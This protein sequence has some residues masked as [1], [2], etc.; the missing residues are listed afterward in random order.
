MH[1]DL[2]HHMHLHALLE[3]LLM[4]VFEVVS[5]NFS[6]ICESWEHQSLE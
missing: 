4:R 6:A 2:R 5:P 3:Y 1:F